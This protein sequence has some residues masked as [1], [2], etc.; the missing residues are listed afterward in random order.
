MPQIPRSSEEE[1]PA[2]AN[3]NLL[4]ISSAMD[5]TG[6]TRVVLELEPYKDIERG[7]G[8][9]WVV[10]GLVPAQGLTVVYGDAGAGKSF[11][12]L[13][14]SLMVASGQCVFGQK[15][16]Q[17][18]VLYLAC[19]GAPGVRSRIEA[20]KRANPP[21]RDLPFFMVGRELRLRGNDADT[22]GVKAAIDEVRHCL[23]A[24]RIPLSLIVIDTLARA[25]NGADENASQDM[26]AL[27]ASFTALGEYAGAAVMVVH[28]SG[29]NPAMGARGHSSLRGAADAMLEVK[30]SAG[31]QKESTVSI[32]KMK[33]ADDSASNLFALEIV[34]LG[35]DDD[36]DPITSCVLREHGTAPKAK[37]LSV[38]EER[39]IEAIRLVAVQAGMSAAD[40]FG[41]DPDL[42]VAKREDVLATALDAGFAAKLP[43][44]SQR[45]AFGRTV[46][47]LAHAGHVGAH[48]VSNREGYLWLLRADVA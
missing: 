40:A 25:S 13:H 11:L 48:Q 24:D 44:N 8:P 5:L 6:D 34:E 14:L 22:E 43:P 33:D 15:C 41:G 4:S 29:K 36:G 17:G 47:R 7:R 42:T 32:A 26:M 18:G 31:G 27:I 28:H 39:L 21:L 16:R 2:P 23:Q 20:F 38:A 3:D 12:A 1:R 35:T 37:T 30:K 9:Q 45:Q 46:Q 19:E 10:K